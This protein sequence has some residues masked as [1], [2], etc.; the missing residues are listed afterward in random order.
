MSANAYD[1]MTTVKARRWNVYRSTSKTL[2]NSNE[3]SIFIDRNNFISM[4]RSI[5]DDNMVTV[6]VKRWN[7][8]STLFALSFATT[9]C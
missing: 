1:Y 3:K 6:N 8:G 5:V 7:T 4:K 2:S 9:H